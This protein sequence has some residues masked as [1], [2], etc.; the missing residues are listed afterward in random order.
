MGSNNFWEKHPLQWHNSLSLMCL[1]FLL[2][3]R[4]REGEGDREREGGEGGEWMRKDSSVMKV[5]GNGPDQLQPQFFLSRLMP[6]GYWMLP[7]GTKNIASI[8]FFIKDS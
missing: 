8:I 1:C 2:N 6:P 5:E 7:S 3:K 4:G